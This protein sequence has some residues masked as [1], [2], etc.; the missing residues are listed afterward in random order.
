MRVR[1]RRAAICP[2]PRPVTRSSQDTALTIADHSLEQGD[3]LRK[4][5]VR[6]VRPREQA[7]VHRRG[8]ADAV[9]S[10]SLRRRHSQ[11]LCRRATAGM[12]LSS[13]AGADHR[14]TSGKRRMAPQ[15][16]VLEYGRASVRSAAHYLQLRQSIVRNRFLQ[17]GNAGGPHPDP[18]ALLTPLALSKT[19]RIE[20]PQA[21]VPPAP[22]IE[23]PVY[24]LIAVKGQEPF[25][26]QRCCNI[27]IDFWSSRRS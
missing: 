8:A 24:D 27:E 25:L 11:Y 15:V 2:A 18:P 10:R 1:D 5:R 4:S 16:R 23:F 13:R 14:A 21:R 20:H 9:R 12:G 22:S 19:E 7:G 3:F 26:L 17:K 6:Q